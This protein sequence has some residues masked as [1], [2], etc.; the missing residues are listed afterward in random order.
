MTSHPRKI[1][2]HASESSLKRGVHTSI[3]SPN[4][5]TAAPSTRSLGS[6]GNHGGRGSSVRRTHGGGGARYGAC[7]IRVPSRRKIAGGRRRATTSELPGI[8]HGPHHAVAGEFSLSATCGVG[9]DKAVGGWP[10]PA[11]ME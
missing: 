3:V 4:H 7:V 2:Q 6:H 8:A 1:Q 10:A 11:M 5:P 9:P